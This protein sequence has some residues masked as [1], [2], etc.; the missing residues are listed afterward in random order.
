MRGE[1]IAEDRLN[2]WLRWSAAIC[3]ITSLGALVTQVAGL[4]PMVFFLTFFGVPSLLLLL[5]MAAYARWIDAT[6]FLNALLVGVVGG[7]VATLAYD[8]IRLL[9]RTSGIFNYDGFVAIYIFGGWITGQETTTLPAALA[10]WTYHFW[11]GLSFGVFYVLTFGNRHWLYGAAYG[12][13]M[14]LCMLGL[15]PFFV[16]VTDR[17]DFIML[18]LIGHLVYGAALGTIAQHWARGW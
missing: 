18:S 13:V 15:F 1:L 14:E 11:N 4:L 6:V 10:G 2:R 3:A 8:G 17:F 12:I 7:F 5:I 16:Q 9:L